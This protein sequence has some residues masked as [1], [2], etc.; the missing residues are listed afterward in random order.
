MSKYI[1]K[2]CPAWQPHEV[3]YC[4]NSGNTRICPVYKD[5]ILKQIVE[6]CKNKDYFVKRFPNA[7]F[8]SGVQN[9]ELAFDILQLLDIQ[10]VE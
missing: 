5:C 3:Y 8:S 7:E 6:L 10:E 2:N 1:I 4:Y 9:S